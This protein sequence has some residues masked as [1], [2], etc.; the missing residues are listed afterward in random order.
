MNEIMYHEEKHYTIKAKGKNEEEVIGKIFT[1]LKKTVTSDIEGIVIKLEPVNVY[2]I[3]KT[4]D[5]YTE[6]FLWFFMPRKK[7]EIEIELKIVVSV[8]YVKI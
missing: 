6:T 7:Q 4:V 1:I 8:K 2:E 3:S 5:E